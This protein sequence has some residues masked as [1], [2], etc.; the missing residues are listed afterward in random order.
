M[1]VSKF[2]E[3]GFQELQTWLLKT[4]PDDLTD[5]DKMAHEIVN[6]ETIELC[7][8]LFFFTAHAL[9]SQT[10]IPKSIYEDRLKGVIVQVEKKFP[11]FRMWLQKVHE[12]NSKNST[13]VCS[14]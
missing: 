9:E 4:N 6:S 12:E 3:K 1:S 8:T 14:I 5:F 2:Q 10:E 11:T 7:V 13:A